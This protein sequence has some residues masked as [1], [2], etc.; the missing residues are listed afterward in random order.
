MVAALVYG[1]RRH[2]KK[3]K[4]A[5]LALS[6]F[7]FCRV[8]VF[9]WLALRA[10]AH[11]D[12]PAAGVAVGGLAALNAYWFPRPLPSR[13]PARRTLPPTEGFAHPLFVPGGRRAP[14]N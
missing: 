11:E 10:F 13:R 12:Q 6:F 14:Q 9:S 8:C 7:F 2:E 5:L 3:E 1:V 4:A